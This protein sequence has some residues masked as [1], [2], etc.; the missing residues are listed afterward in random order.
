MEKHFVVFCSPGTFIS[1]R[2][3][4]PIDSWN[5]DKAKKMAKKVKERYNATP[6][7]FYFIT[8][9]RKSTELDSKTVKSS[10][11]YFL[12]GTILTL[13]EII[14]RN[15]PE[16]DILISNMKRNEWDQVIENCNSWRVVLPFE[17]DAV[18]LEW[19]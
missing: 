6:Y 13:Q 1:E 11:M 8:R 2:T 14:A 10:G 5:V 16:D 19:P 3:E 9:A 15:N 12:G 18:R 4:K 17:K 7:G